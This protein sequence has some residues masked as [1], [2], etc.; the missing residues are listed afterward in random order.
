MIWGLGCGERRENIC[1]EI[2]EL[3]AALLSRR[4]LEKLRKRGVAFKIQHRLTELAS[5]MAGFE[6]P[7]SSVSIACDPIILTMGGESASRWN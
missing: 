1:L 7:D 2:K 6:T 4:L 5:D 3:K